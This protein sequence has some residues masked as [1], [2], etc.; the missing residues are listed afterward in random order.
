MLLTTLPELSVAIME[1]A[2]RKGR[3]TIGDMMLLTGA[4]RNT[5]KE[6][7]RKLVAQGY[8]QKYG[9]RKGAWYGL[10]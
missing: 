1:E 6:H 3:V 4:N 7:F 9:E 5:L 8:L 10:V 2:K